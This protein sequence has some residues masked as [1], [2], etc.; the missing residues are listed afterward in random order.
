MKASTLKHQLTA[1]EQLA[2]RITVPSH[3]GNM[4]YRRWS[5]PAGAETL[6]LVHG[7]SGSWLHWYR[8]IEF[9]Q[10]HCHVI[11]ADLPGLGDSAALQ[12][13]YTAGDAVEAFIQGARAVIGSEAFHMAAFSWG[14]AVSAQS[15]IHFQNQLRSLLL[16]GPASLGED[17]RRSS[18][19]PLI[20]RTPEMSESEVQAANL[21]NLARL[22]IHDRSRIDEMAIYI[23]TLNTQKARFNS[24][25]FARTTLV[26]DGVAGIQTP[27]KVVY[28]AYDAPALPDVAGKRALFNAVNSEVEFEVV[29]DAGHWL[30]Y[31]QPEAFNHLALNWLSANCR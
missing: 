30:Q 7:G 21:E 23:Q 28:G 8:N 19:K 27:V 5:G 26:L 10:Q 13:G 11:A 18:M 31:E 4:V 1:L 16:V 24:P 14:C 15:A 22:M 6:L 9:L 25:Q 12:E 20:R 29:P 3:E 17:P 2:E